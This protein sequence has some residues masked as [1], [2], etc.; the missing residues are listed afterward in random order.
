MKSLAHA[1]RKWSNTLSKKGSSKRSSPVC[2]LPIQQ[3]T[4]R[5]TNHPGVQVSPNS[6]Q[7]AAEGCSD[8]L[9]SLFPDA[10]LS[11]INQGS[12][13][14]K[15][16]LS[17]WLLL[18]WPQPASWS[19]SA[20]RTLVGHLQRMWPFQRWRCA[21]GSLLE[22]ELCLRGEPVGQTLLGAI[23]HRQVGPRSVRRVV[24]GEQ[25]PDALQERGGHIGPRLRVQHYQTAVGGR[26]V[27]DELRRAGTHIGHHERPPPVLLQPIARGIADQIV[28]GGQDR[29]VAPK[30]R[31]VPPGAVP[32]DAPH[33]ERGNE[34]LP[35][36]PH[37]ATPPPRGSRGA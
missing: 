2:H 4:T 24:H 28:S 23:R 35:P 32:P 13:L 25:H 20:R 29:G 11:A 37:P 9:A 19:I 34:S 12:A 16:R 14:S 3:Q 6:K 17:F 8:R 30:R 7:A 15:Y 5:H 36:R 33:N 1:S 22:G 31:G 26:R 21:D 18:C 27:G 10:P